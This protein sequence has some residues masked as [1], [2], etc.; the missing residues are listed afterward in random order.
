MSSTADYDLN[1]SVQGSAC[2]RCATAYGARDPVVDQGL[3]CPSCL[4]QGY[5][6]SL[7]LVYASEQERAIRQDLR[8]MMRYAGQLPY[9]TFPSLGEGG[10]PLLPLPSLAHRLGLAGI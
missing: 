5:P 3:G 9:Q 6:A 4:E 2:L 8:G 10:T 1:P 7:R